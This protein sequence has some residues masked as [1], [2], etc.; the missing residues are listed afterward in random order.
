MKKIIIFI[1]SVLALILTFI[2]AEIFSIYHFGSVLTLLT[3]LYLISMFSI[4]EYLFISVTYIVRKL[5]KKEK[6]KIKSIIGLVLLFIALLLVTLFL[7]I[8][9]ID[10]L[11][12]YP[13]L[14]PFYIN[15]IVR[16]VE[17]L[18][19]ATILIYLS[20]LLLRNNNKK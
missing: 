6:L 9:N 4:L 15:V 20:V 10:W 13:Y 1:L 12:W 16:G 17:F 11:N 18:L 3:S 8:I 14:G 5:I 19:P 2:V 7:V